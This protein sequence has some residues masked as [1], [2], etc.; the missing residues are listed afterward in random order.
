MTCG[1]LI[2]RILLSNRRYKQLIGAKHVLILKTYSVKQAIRKG[3]HTGEFYI[4]EVVKQA[5]LIY[6]SKQS[7]SGCLLLR[8]WLDMDIREISGGMGSLRNI[9]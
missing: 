5:K 6:E 3:A 9:F 1:I 8:D 2:S 7:E 4:Y